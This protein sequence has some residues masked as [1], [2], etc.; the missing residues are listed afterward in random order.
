MSLS[1]TAPQGESAGDRLYESSVGVI[2]TIIYVVF[3][4]KQKVAF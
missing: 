3:L 2:Q 4:N 1:E